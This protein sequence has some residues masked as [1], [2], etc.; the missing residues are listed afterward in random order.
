MAA[1][2]P[3]MTDEV[4]A[5]VIQA[6]A[7]F[8]SPS[9]VA[10][11]VKAEYGIVLSPQAVQLYDPTKYAGRKLAA[12]WKTM[13]EKARKVFIDDTSG[14]PIAH[15][16]TRLRALQRMAQAA[17]RKGNFPLAAQLHKQAAEEMGNAYTNRRELTGKGGKDLP[18]AAPA[19]AVF[20]LPD[21][22]R[23]A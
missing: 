12:K 20:A 3:A 16:S 8:D 5:F 18:S 11:A 13:F 7:S 6:L 22:G 19:V 17:E 21:N 1:N 9:Q 4:K 23:D 14:I 15:R 10:D 2:N